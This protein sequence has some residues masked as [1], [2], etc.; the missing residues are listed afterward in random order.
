[1][2]ILSIIA[3][4]FKSFYRTYIYANHIN[5]FG[6]ADSSP[7]FFAGLIIV[8]FYFTQYQNMS[9]RKYAIY[10]AIGLVGYELIQGT[11]F[12]HNYFDYKDII[13]SI[14]GTYVGY[15]IGAKLKREPILDGQK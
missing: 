4:L 10:S 11:V 1:M 3:I 8:F 9:L 14:L 12:K 7:N 13:A 5:D 2:I 6:I 15:L